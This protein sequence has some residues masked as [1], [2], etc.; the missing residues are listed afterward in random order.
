M[1]LYSWHV[2]APYPE[3]LLVPLF[4]SGAV[5][6]TNLTQY[7]NPEVDKAL[8]EA[9]H[10][11][12]GPDQQRAYARATVDR[13]GCPDGLYSRPGWREPVAACKGSS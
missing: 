9:L 2:R 7:Q 13:G 8:D 4:H 1:F 6:A 11:P 5:G 12:D 10:L 3:R